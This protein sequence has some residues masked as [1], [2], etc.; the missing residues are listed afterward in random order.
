MLVCVYAVLFYSKTT[1]LLTGH[2]RTI[3]GMEE[4]KN[5]SVCMLL[6]DPGCPSGDMKKL[7]TSSTAAGCVGR[8]RKFPGHLKH[9]QYQVVMVEGVLSP[10]ERQVKHSISIL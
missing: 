4:R 3:V 2:S 5:G 1:L 6:L 7:L 10:E 9:T 8:M